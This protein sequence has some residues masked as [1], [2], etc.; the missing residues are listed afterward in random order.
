MW[1][2]RAEAIY[3]E[4]EDRGHRRAAAASREG[5]FHVQPT[6]AASVELELGVDVLAAGEREDFGGTSWIRTCSPISPRATIRRGL[7]GAGS[8]RE[9]AGRGLR[10]GATATTCRIE[11]SSSHCAIRLAPLRL[12]LAAGA[13]DRQRSV[14]RREPQRPCS[15]MGHRLSKIYT[16]TGDD[17]TTGLGDGTRVPKTHARI[18]AYG[19]VDEANSAH[20]HGA[21]GAGIAGRGRQRADADSA[22]AVRSR[23]RAR[24][25]GLSRH[26]AG[27]GRRAGAA[28]RSTSTSR[29]RR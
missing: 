19:T 13:G 9:R 20:R 22:R 11:A 10:A 5:E 23:R 26:H 8:R 18:E 14:F 24:R 2:L 16:R 15:V 4:P 6:C 21:R 17:G 3:Q 27:A 28:A 1:R 25:A 29:C 12:S 7:V